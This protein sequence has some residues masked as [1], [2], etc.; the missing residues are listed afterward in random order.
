MK[1]KDESLARSMD[2]LEQTL[3]SLEDSF[4]LLSTVGMV[5]KPLQKTYAPHN[6]QVLKWAW[7]EKVGQTITVSI[8][9]HVSLLKN[10]L[11]LPKMYQMHDRACVC[12]FS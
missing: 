10:T 8:L 6:M 1:V 5:K 9:A 3:L 11:I 7:C 2:E 12:R 4:E